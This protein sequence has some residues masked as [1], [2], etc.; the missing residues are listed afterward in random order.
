M[1]ITLV[2]LLSTHALMHTHTPTHPHKDDTL[3]V[4]FRTK[5]NE[6]EDKPTRGPSMFSCISNTQPAEETKA[7]PTAATDESVQEDEPPP[8]V[9]VEAVVLRAHVG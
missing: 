3:T 8:P 7:E 2:E 4:K 6:Q 5:E 1:R 9:E